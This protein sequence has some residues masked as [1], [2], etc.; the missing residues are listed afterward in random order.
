MSID[1]EARAKARKPNHLKASEPTT[2]AIE[3]ETLP[4]AP[5]QEETGMVVGKSGTRFKS[6][7][8]SREEMRIS[9][10]QESRDII[11]KSKNGQYLRPRSTRCAD[12]DWFEKNKL[13]VQAMIGEN[14]G[15]DKVKR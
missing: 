7:Q 14:I 2:E 5:E 10:F 12:R 9:A 3:S 6:T 4:R 11:A 13:S 15:L 1:R 8:E